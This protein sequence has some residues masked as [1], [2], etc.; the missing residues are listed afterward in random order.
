MRGEQIDTALQEVRE[1]L[2]PSSSSLLSQESTYQL[3]EGSVNVLPPLY[4]M[5]STYCAYRVY[6]LIGLGIMVIVLAGLF[7][8]GGLLYGKVGSLREEAAAGEAKLATYH[9]AIDAYEQALDRLSQGG[10]THKAEVLHILDEANRH[11]IQ[12][13]SIVFEDKQLHIQGMAP[14]AEVLHQFTSGI[15]THVKGWTFQ[16]KESYKELDVSQAGEGQLKSKG[17][18]IESKDMVNNSQELGIE[19][20]NIA[21]SPKDIANSPKNL[22]IDSKDTAVMSK[23]TVVARNTAQQVRGELYAVANET[24]E[25][26]SHR[27]LSFTLEG[28]AKSS[29]S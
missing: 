2:P 17:R 19:S 26:L 10:S 14:S 29:S 28:V 12:L 4:R 8:Y 16:S 21:N 9:Q 23:D 6:G 1:S 13:E 22:S 24:S 20:E 27:A 7:V 5:E 25:E 11:H 3:P 15:K 18:A